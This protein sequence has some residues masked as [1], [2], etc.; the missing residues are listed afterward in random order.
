MAQG[1][2][3]LEDSRRLRGQDTGQSTAC[4]ADRPSLALLHLLE[5]CYSTRA[6]SFRAVHVDMY[7]ATRQYIT[8]HVCWLLIW[9]VGIIPQFCW[10]IGFLVGCCLAWCQAT[11]RCTSHHKG[12]TPG[13]TRIS[14]SLC[15]PWPSFS[16]IPQLATRVRCPASRPCSNPLTA[17]SR[18][19]AG[20]KDLGGEQ[21]ASRG[22]GPRP[23]GEGE[24][25]A[26]GGAVAW[27]RARGACGGSL[28]AIPKE[29]SASSGRTLLPP[30]WGF[31]LSANGRRERG[32]GVGLLRGARRGRGTK[33]RRMQ[34]LV[35]LLIL[36]PQGARFPVTSLASSLRYPTC[37]RA[38]LHA[39]SCP[40]TSA[41]VSLASQEHRRICTLP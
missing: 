25:G 2:E 36:L 26:G 24:G 23:G 37:A 32:V 39:H 29:A 19:R 14:E 12:G 9:F 21:P 6:V 20:A 1:L 18:P 11:V 38:L 28:G 41:Q 15:F 31:N 27:E 8:P 5:S 35:S 34:R 10:L 3:R 40:H 30:L 17:Q 4:G 13:S 7:I 22:K 33:G 16:Q